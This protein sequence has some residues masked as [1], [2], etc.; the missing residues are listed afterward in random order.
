MLAN[1]VEVDSGHGREQQAWSAMA[2]FWSD[3]EEGETAAM[4]GEAT[5][6]G[7]YWRLGR[8][9]QV[10]ELLCAAMATSSWWQAAAK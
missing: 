10:H 8:D 2:A 9:Q 4:G 1:R 6:M 5:A 7:G 3:R